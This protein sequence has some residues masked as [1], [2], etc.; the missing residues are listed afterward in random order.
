MYEL[1]HY[2]QDNLVEFLLFDGFVFPRLLYLA[3]KKDPD[4]AIRMI[5]K[6]LEID[7]RCDFAYETLGTIEVQR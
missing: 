2:V 5:Q 1:L 7:S 4:Q 3:W 6:A